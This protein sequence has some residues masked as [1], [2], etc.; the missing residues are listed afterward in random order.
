METFRFSYLPDYAGYLLENKLTEFVTVSIRFSRDAELPL[1]KPLSKFSEK[2]LVDLS[3]E[4]SSEMLLALKEGR[5]E[6]HIRENTKKWLDNKLEV[7]HKD[8]ILAEDVTLLFYIRRKTFAH[9]LDAYTKNVVLQK[10]IIAEVDYYTTQEE[11][12]SYNAYLKMHSRN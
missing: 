2:E 5:I 6:Q 10:F 11:L 8:E 7:V 1:L 12:I 4:S 3:M 9:F